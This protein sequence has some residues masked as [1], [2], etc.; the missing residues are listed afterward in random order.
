MAV[1]LQEPSSKKNILC[2]SLTFFFV[3]GIVWFVKLTVN[4]DIEAS[5]CK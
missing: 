5:S 3:A 2:E 1:E 4:E